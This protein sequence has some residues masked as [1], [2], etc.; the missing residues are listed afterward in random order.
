MKL[1]LKELLGNNTTHWSKSR[2]ILAGAAL[3]V[4]AVL[5]EEWEYV[6]FGVVFVVLRFKTKKAINQ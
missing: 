2:T 6:A 3:C 5:A 4:Y 1:F